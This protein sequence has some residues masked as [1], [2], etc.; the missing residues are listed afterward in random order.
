VRN[1][2]GGGGSVNQKQIN[3]KLYDAGK[4]QNA[5]ML[6]QPRATQQ[7]IGSIVKELKIKL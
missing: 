4:G 2:E 1:I 3:I 7:A 5:N 6:P